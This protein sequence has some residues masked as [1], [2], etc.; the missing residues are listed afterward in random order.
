MKE[1]SLRL[2]AV[3]IAVI[4]LFSGCA[5]KEE[6]VSETDTSIPETETVTDVEPEEEPETLVFEKQAL[7]LDEIFSDA[8]ELHKK[9]VTRND[10]EGYEEFVS[11]DSGRDVLTDAEVKMLMKEK[12]DPDSLTKEQAL[13]DIDYLFRI[14]RSTFAEYDYFGRENFENA[15]KELEDEISKRDSIT[16]KGFVA[17]ANEKLSFIIDRHSDIGAHHKCGPEWKSA[18]SS[19]ISF[20]SDD[21]GFFAVSGAE[22]WY[23]KGASDENILI[24]KVLHGDGIVDYAPVLWAKEEEIKDSGYLLYLE[25]ETGETVDLPLKFTECVNY[26]ETPIYET[27][28]VFAESEHNAYVSIRNFTKQDIN[29]VHNN[30]KE[31]EKVEAEAYKINGHDSVI[32]DMR[33]NGGGT[34]EVDK[35][36]YN[37][38]GQVPKCSNLWCELNSRYLKIYKG[39]LADRLSSYNV[40]KTNGKTV[41]NKDRKIFVLMDRNNGSWGEDILSMMKTIEN[42]LI[43]GSNSGGYQIGGNVAKLYLPNSGMLVGV[44]TKMEFRIVGMENIDGKGYAPDIWCDPK[45]AVGSVIKMMEYYGLSNAEELDA[46]S[47]NIEDSTEIAKLEDP[48]ITLWFEGVIIKA[49]DGFGNN[50]PNLAVGVQVNGKGTKSFEVTNDNPKACNIYKGEDGRVHI[51]QT[52]DEISAWFGITVGEKTSKFHV[53]LS[54]ADDSS[55]G[56]TDIGIV[57]V[58][59]GEHELVEGEFFGD[60]T[61][62]NVAEVFL[63]GNKITDYEIVNENPEY[64]DIYS[65]S[66]GRLFIDKKEK[67]KDIVFRIIIG[68]KSAEFKVHTGNFPKN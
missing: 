53:H 38:L 29:N 59:S 25:S 44:S 20:L 47:K 14:L 31:V 40:V 57:L 34:F 63:D 56:R 7:S 26:N 17:L 3:F 16:N 19:D 49:G 23:Y 9:L 15:R 55:K 4:C 30:R 60:A 6:P 37:W 50:K 45:E 22:K 68:E 52:S 12:N 66:D 10:Y 51:E 18:I 1:L 8:N 28:Y 43:I 67:Y 62:Y 32:M 46:F 13:E 65:V 48:E 39:F 21:K 5:E 35:W 11:Y 27:D 41:E 58:F 36:F 33:S 24:T 54:A 61:P 2:A 42:V 64:G